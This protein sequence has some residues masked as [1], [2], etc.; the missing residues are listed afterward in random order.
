M[1]IANIKTKYFIF[2]IIKKIYKSIIYK[3]IKKGVF[4]HI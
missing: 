2:V 4:I 3:F 1:I